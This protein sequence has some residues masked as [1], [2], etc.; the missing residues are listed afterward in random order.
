MSPIKNNLPIALI[1]SRLIIGVLI[2]FL[3][4]FHIEH[5][6]VIAVILFTTGLLTDILDGIIARRLNISTQHLR[7]L[8]ST[9]DQVFFVLVA[10]ATFIQSPDFF[11]QNS[12]MLIVL[13]S[14]EAMTYLI[15]FIKFRKEVATHAIASKIWT[16]ILFATLIEIILT[17]TSTI[18]F[19]ICFYTGMAT[20]L[21]I[22]GIILLLPVWTNDVPGLYQAV[23]LRQ[24]KPIKRHKLFNG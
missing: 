15:C 17:G 6:N 5:Y 7:R 22:I 11:Y 16:L 8:D 2:L 20:R 12:I 18:L 10:I 19:Q 14:T 13:L 3:S 4:V 24:G 23:L 9:I 1:Y 21:E